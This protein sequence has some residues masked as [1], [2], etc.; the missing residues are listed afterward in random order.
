MQVFTANPTA[1]QELGWGSF[2][3]DTG[4]FMDKHEDQLTKFGNTASDLG[5]N[6][7]DMKS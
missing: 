4:D 5:N 1:L 7:M 6:Y 2:L 3:S